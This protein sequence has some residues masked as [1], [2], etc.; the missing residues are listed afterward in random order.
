MSTELV[1][2]GVA[3]VKLG[4]LNIADVEGN[5]SAARRILEIEANKRIDEAFE[6]EKSPITGHHWP[7]LATYT[8]RKKEDLEVQGVI[9]PGAATSIMVRTG[10][11]R[12]LTKA[13][14]TI[15]GDS[16]SAFVVTTKHGYYNH[17]GSKGGQHVV[18]RPKKPGG[19][20]RF[21]AKDGDVVFTRKPI[22]ITRK[23]LKKRRYFGFYSRTD[24]A[25]LITN[26]L[27]GR[28]RR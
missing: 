17:E 10:E 18:I 13:K 23:G 14:A 15:D 25:K 8:M 19:F 2:I 24:I 7:E 21:V 1:R 9:A 5:I 27:A 26:A 20:L 12:Q 16:I 11:T 3:V 6:N 4:E 22:E 28:G